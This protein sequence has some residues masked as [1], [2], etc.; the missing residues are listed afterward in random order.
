[1]LKS[2]RALA[3]ASHMPIIVTMEFPH[4]SDHPGKAR[5]GDTPEADPAAPGT[6]ASTGSGQEGIA[7]ERLKQV[8]RNLETG[9]YDTPEVREQIARRVREELGP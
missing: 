7:P 3:D 5:D 1:M 4:E 2:R 8:I 9:F 6:D